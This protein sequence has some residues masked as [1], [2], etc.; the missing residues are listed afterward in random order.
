M[1]DLIPNNVV[2][3]NGGKDLNITT[4]IPCKIINEG[5]YLDNGGEGYGSYIRLFGNSYDRNDYNY[6]RQIW[7]LEESKTYGEYRISS[8][9]NYL[10]TFGGGH[11]SE[12]RVSSRNHNDNP[13]LSK[14][15]W[16]FST[17]MISETE[18]VQIQSLSNK[19]YLDNW[20]GYSTVHFNEYLN[21]PS[22]PV[23][24][25]QLWKFEIADYKLKVDIENF[26]YDKKINNL[27]SYT[28]KVSSVIFTSRNLSSSNPWKTEINLSEKTPNITSW[29]FNKSK[30]LTFLDKLD[31]DVKA[32]YA[33]VKGTFHEII[34]WNNKSTSL[35][36]IKKLKLDE[37]NISGKYSIEIQNK[38]EVEVKIIWHK[39]NLDIQ[40]T[41]MAKIK[42]FSDRLRKN[43]TIAKMEQVDA[44][45][46]SLFLK[47][48]GFKGKTI[49]EGK[50]VLVE[51][52]G[53]VNI[54]GAIKCEIE[55]SSKFLSN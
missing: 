28:T 42:G 33:G 2:H 36:N 50:N 32:E 53:N 55:K 11:E 14:Q 38:E 39:V 44:N 48:S 35:E 46:M 52:T 1:E 29:S 30:E 49:T 37:T 26:K 20:G 4:G 6:A 40:F 24:S 8:D 7:F 18:E 17:Q 51:I 23:Y 22:D 16:T 47:N 41:A 27:D 9:R 34:K 12:V 54:Q 31:V 21:K 15:L 3:V 19:C 43:G 10:D 45:A 13:D 25:R 5:H